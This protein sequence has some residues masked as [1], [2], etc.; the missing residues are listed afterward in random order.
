MSEEEK[1]IETLENGHSVIMPSDTVY[2][3]F[4]DCTN[5][6]AIKEV[7]DIKGSNKPHLIVVSS[8]DMLSKY[9][10]SMTTLHKMIINKYWPNTLTIL[11][12][13]S[14]LIPEELTKSS[15]LVGVRMPNNKMLLDI[16]SK[17]NKPLLSTSANITNENVITDISMLDDRIK[18]KVGYIYDGGH[19][20]SE[21]STIIKIENNKIIF[22]REGSLAPKIKED[23]NN[24]L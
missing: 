22:L 18:N 4:A 23:F 2:G 21:A 7:D 11:F 8:L 6:S 10:K 12:E 14:E 5:N 20:G 9:V 1:I 3:I 19:L 13:K 16:I 17:F 24:Y 15:S